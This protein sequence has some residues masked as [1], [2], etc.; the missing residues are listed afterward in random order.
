M[1]CSE[2]GSRMK[3]SFITFEDWEE[4]LNGKLR[5]VKRSKKTYECPKCGHYEDV[6]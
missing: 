2:C 6:D 1:K 3:P 4:D 5:K